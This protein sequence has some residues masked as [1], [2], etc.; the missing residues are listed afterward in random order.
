MW[1]RTSELRNVSLNSTC[2]HRQLNG[3]AICTQQLIFNKSYIWIFNY[4]LCSELIRHNEHWTVLCLIKIVFK[5]P[6]CSTFI[7]FIGNALTVSWTA[8]SLVFS[9]QNMEILKLSKEL[10]QTIGLYDRHMTRLPFVFF[11][12]FAVTFFLVVVMG[13]CFLFV[14]NN[15][16][17]FVLAARALL[18][19][20]ALLISC[21]SYW[22]LIVQKNEISDVL[23]G[24]ETLVNESKY[25]I[26]I[27]SPFGWISRMY[28]TQITLVIIHANLIF[29]MMIILLQESN[30]TRI[31]RIFMSWP[32]PST[33][34][35]VAYFFVIFS[36][37]IQSLFYCWHY[38]RFYSG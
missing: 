25:T 13:T 16:S 8:N 23:Q 18:P 4:P 29:P 38:R 14:V 11:K 19:T 33:L 34:A 7:I 20:F 3:L 9:A 37:F 31:G 6:F 15:L 12:Y 30:W 21:A 27:F 22:I 36:V 24:F 32:R 28:C 17:N 2:T 26:T 1:R 35:F 5:H 10:L